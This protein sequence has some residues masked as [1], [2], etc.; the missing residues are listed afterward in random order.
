MPGSRSQREEVRR[1]K[2]SL[3]VCGDERLYHQTGTEEPT[4]RWQPVLIFAHPVPYMMGPSRHHTPC[5]HCMGILALVC[6][7][8]TRPFQAQSISVLRSRLFF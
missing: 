5:T 2:E 8:R 4:R 6:P 7:H 1:E 3:C